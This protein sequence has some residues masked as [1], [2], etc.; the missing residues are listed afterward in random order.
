MITKKELLVIIAITIAI[1]GGVI[2][3][4]KYAAIYNVIVAV[5]ALGL[6][7]YAGWLTRKLF[8]RFRN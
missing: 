8:N 3:Y 4:I 1:L 7:F 2:L 6:G 5:L